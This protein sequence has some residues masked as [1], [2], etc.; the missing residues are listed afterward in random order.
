MTLSAACTVT[1]VFHIGFIALVHVV[2]LL[3]VCSGHIWSWFV[4]HRIQ[5][6]TICHNL[7]FVA[8]CNIVFL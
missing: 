8:F 1:A 4:N 2:I 3:W 6:A 5:L 7:W